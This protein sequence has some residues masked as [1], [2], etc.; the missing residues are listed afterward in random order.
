[1]H[2]MLPQVLANVLLSSSLY[3]M[4]AVSFS[5]IYRVT[6]CFLFSH[7][8]MITAG[9]YLVLSAKKTLG[10]PLVPAIGAG[11][12]TAALLGGGVNRVVYRP[13]RRR[14]SSALVQ[15]LASLG[16][17]MVLQNIISMIFGDYTQL[18]RSDSVSEGVNILGARITV[19]QIVTIASGIGVTAIVLLIRKQTRIGR[20]MMAVASSPELAT[21]S[22]IDAE[23]AIMWASALGAAIAGLAGILIALDIDMVPTMGMTYLLM[24]IVVMIVGG[25][26]S[27][28]GMVAAAIL[29]ASVQHASSLL[30]GAQWKEA[31]AFIVLLA[32]LLAKPFVQRRITRRGGA[33][34]MT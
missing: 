4:I 26:R 7:G 31:S 34:S 21:V 8:V 22:G 5:V 6:R 28:W 9:A 19:I 10:M 20:A 3:L 16:V 25:A 12:V 29:V 15:M 18:I 33:L 1:M 14:R 13:L 11:I 32:V 27:V 24:G 30:L 2:T 23:Q 17:Y